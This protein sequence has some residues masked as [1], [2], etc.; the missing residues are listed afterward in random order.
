MNNDSSLGNVREEKNDKTRQKLKKIKREKLK[1]ESTR[2]HSPKFCLEGRAIGLY[3][4]I[5]GQFYN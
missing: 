3:D 1:A 2:G 4:G 5:Y